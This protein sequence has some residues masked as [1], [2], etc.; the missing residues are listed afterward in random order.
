MENDW[1]AALGALAASLPQDLTDEQTQNPSEPEPKPAFK[2][3]KLHISFERKGRA[4]KCATI[5]SGFDGLS[6]SEIAEIASQLKRSL[7][8][9]GSSR[10]GEILIQGD[11][12]DDVARYFGLKKHK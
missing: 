7:A 5:I 2:P 11:R 6:D 3:G 9:G 10:G 1:K 8:T 12:R 4:G